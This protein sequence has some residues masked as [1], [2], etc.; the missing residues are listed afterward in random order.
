VQAG[1]DDEPS[2]RALAGL[3]SRLFPP[4][5]AVTVVRGAPAARAAPGQRFLPLPPDRP[6]VLVPL[7]GLAAA[8]GS[9]VPNQGL[10]STGERVARRVLAVALRTGLPQAALRNRWQGLVGADA[11]RPL[12][13]LLTVLRDEWRHDVHALALTVR[14]DTPNHKPTFVALDHHGRVLGFGKLGVDDGTNQRLAQEVAGLTRMASSPV[15]GLRTPRPLADLSWCGRRVVV[16]EPLASDARRH[17]AH[18]RAP[19]PLVRE[20]V[21]RGVTQPAHATARSLVSEIERIDDPQLVAAARAAEDRVGQR[22][23]DVPVAVGSMHGDWVPWNLAY[24]RGETW[25]F[26]WEH[27]RAQGPVGLDVAHWHQLVCWQREGLGFD[28]ALAEAQVR[29][30]RDLRRTGLSADE[31]EALVALADLHAA[32]R[33]AG[34][35]ESSGRWRDGTRDALLTR[36]SPARR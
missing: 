5:I 25:A 3:A 29:T 28:G 9:L 22:F 15:A 7:E 20:A 8:A 23:A 33:A 24:R 16:V 32:A 30:Q 35:F 13:N 11:D 12:P 31:L 10:R 14:E 4:D 27:S 1:S 21:A 19:L 2:T 18:A 26:D 17:P 6:R 36:L 34:L